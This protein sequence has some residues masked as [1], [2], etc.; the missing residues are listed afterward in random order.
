VRVLVVDDSAYQ[1]MVLASALR[2]IPTIREV[3]T[4]A[5]GEEAIRLVTTRTFDLVTLDLVM[6]GL[7]GF[8]VL[9]WLMANRPVP[10]LIVSDRR[11]DRTALQA[12]DLGA[13]DVLGKASP[14]AGGLDEWKAALSHVV[15]EAAALRLDL[16][17]GRSRVESAREAPEPKAFPAH[18][19][20]PAALVVA[21]STGGPASLRDLF[22]HLPK[23][24]IVVGVVQ[25][26]P[27]PFTRSL[28]ARLASSTAWEA[29][30][31]RAGDEVR[32]GSLMLAP[33]DQHLTFE[34]RGARIVARLS[35]HRGSLRW[36]PSADALFTSA[37]EIL[38]RNV[39]AVV[40]TGMGDDGAEGA[41]AV[42]SAGGVVV[43]ESAET[44]LIP[45]MPDSAARAVPAA[46]RLPLHAI[47]PEIA[48]WYAGLEKVHSPAL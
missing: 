26:M 3:E 33:G 7:D 46:Q 6:P 13:F 20:P 43:C 12:L 38:G 39:M 37:A 9:R 1:R 42:S 14:R 10:V 27:A 41:R 11:H 4:A 18:P 44:A 2:E 5:S 31:A 8:G 40:L 45:G 29:C 30:E 35:T 22:A 16:L 23:L 48:R 36:C 34:R 28:A 47:A 21:A 15:A 17:V 25:H 32:P 24:P 19:V